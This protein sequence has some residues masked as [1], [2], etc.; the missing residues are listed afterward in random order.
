MAHWLD[1]FNKLQVSNDLRYKK[2]L[3]VNN[4]FNEINSVGNLTAEAREARKK[5]LMVAFNGI[6]RQDLEKY[7]NQQDPDMGR[8]RHQDLAINRQF[9]ERMND[10]ASEFERKHPLWAA[11]QALLPPGER[12]QN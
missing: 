9:G 12:R 7:L 10:L 2:A 11:Y 4:P 6:I 3:A 5:A 8:F 1:S